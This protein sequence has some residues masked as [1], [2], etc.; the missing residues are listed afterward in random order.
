MHQYNY[1]PVIQRTLPW[2]HGNYLPNRPTAFKILRW[3]TCPLPLSPSSPCQ[4]PR[5]ESFLR[6]GLRW[7]TIHPSSLKQ[8]HKSPQPELERER[9][10]EEEMSTPRDLLARAR[11]RWLKPLRTSSSCLRAAAGGGA[12]S[13]S[14][15][16]VARGGSNH[17]TLWLEW[18]R[19]TDPSQ[20]IPKRSSL[21]S[22]YWAGSANLRADPHHP[23]Q[24][25]GA[26][27]EYIYTEILQ[28]FQRVLS[29]LIL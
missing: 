3:P 14:P 21:G 18:I 4:S 26:S 19:S 17:S 23:H 12:P 6:A 5:S 11:F 20:L 29:I 8:S 25:Y 7:T 27:D 10:R 16:G 9:E 13:W 1:N 15:K 22:F 2:F 24:E 28:T